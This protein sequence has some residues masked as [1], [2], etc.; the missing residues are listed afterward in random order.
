MADDAGKKKRGRKKGDPKNKRGAKKTT[1]EEFMGKMLIAAGPRIDHDET[2]EAE[3]VD[4]SHEFGKRRECIDPIEFC[5]AVINN[6]EEI[7]SLCGVREPIGLEDKLAAAKV[8]APYTN[9]KKPVETVSKHQF[10]WV[11]EITEAENRTRNLR[12]DIEENDRAPA[13]TH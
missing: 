6:N 11:D 4:A 8:A 7:L 1:P 3:P 2:I 5:Q 10:S 9:K 13:S 12:M